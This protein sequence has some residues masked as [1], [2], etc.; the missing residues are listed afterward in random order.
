MSIFSIA[1]SYVQLD[2]LIVFS[3]GYRLTITISIKS[4]TSEQSS[5]SLKDFARIPACIFGCSVFTLPPRISSNSVKSDT[6]TF[7]MLMDVKYFAVPPVD[8]IV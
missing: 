3:K 8:N 5:R 4:Y 7:G 2:L 1:S 6:E